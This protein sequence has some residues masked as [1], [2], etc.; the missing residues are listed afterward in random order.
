MKNKQVWGGVY[1]CNNCDF[2]TP[3]TNPDPR[4]GNLCP[5][6]TTGNIELAPFGQDEPAVEK[7]P[8]RQT[9]IKT[10]VEVFEM[11]VEADLQE[12][13]SYK[14]VDAK[15]VPISMKTKEGELISMKGPDE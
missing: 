2:E 4:A 14:V 1:E 13:G 9:Y 10:F 7:K 15:R 12:D 3:E 5:K 8:L 6:C 11:H